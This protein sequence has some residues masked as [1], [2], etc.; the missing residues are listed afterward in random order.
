MSSRTAP[1][2]LDLTGQR[3][4]VTGGSGGIGRAVCARMHEAG[5]SVIV[6]YLRNASGAREL[7]T[8][9]GGVTHERVSIRQANL[10]NV[11]ELNELVDFIAAE[12]GSLDAIVHCASLGTF[13][14]L[15]QTKPS[16]WDLTV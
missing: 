3:C 2:T 4:L 9:L 7:A 11:D 13:K 15:V 1:L 14:P 8:Q 5:A 10:A 6:H 16:H 12:H